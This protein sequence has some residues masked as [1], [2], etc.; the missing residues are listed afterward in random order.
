[1]LA[2]ALG[3]AGGCKVGVD[4][5]D[6]RHWGP[7]ARS[8]VS[9]RREAFRRFWSASMS[10]IHRPGRMVRSPGRGMRRRRT[11]RRPR[12][13][14][15]PA[16]R[17]A[18]RRP[19]RWSSS[20]RRRDAAAALRPTAGCPRLSARAPAGRGNC[21]RVPCRLLGPARLEGPFCLA[22]LHRAA[23]RRDAREPR[24]LR[25]HASGAGAGQGL[26]G[27]ARPP[28]PWPRSHRRPR[29]PRVPRSRSKRNGR[30]A[31]S[32]SRPRRACRRAPIAKAR[33]FTWRLPT[34]ASR[35]T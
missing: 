22:G 2:Q 4:S 35:P 12:S 23:V 34:T 33:S 15:P 6:E 14:A 27:M 29:S 1:M 30:A 5:S 32:P 25:L 16:T 13:S 19:F 9:P 7:R 24:A 3:V 21:A 26:S 8:G 31:R 11:G 18:D 28:R 20:T 17:R 10:N